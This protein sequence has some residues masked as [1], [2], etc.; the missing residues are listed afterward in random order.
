M[1]DG[2]DISLFKILFLLFIFVPLIEIYLLIE[3]GAHIGA[4]P[5]IALIIFTAVL[6]VFLLRLQGLMTLAKV[7]HSMD[8][9]E[10]P[11]A[12]LLEGL[13][14]LIAA[15][16]LLTP[17]FFTVLKDLAGTN[18]NYFTANRLFCGGVRDHDASSAGAFLLHALDDHAI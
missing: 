13:M 2:T 3:I 1:N 11:A 17:G 6:G 12:A 8:Q 9:G 7:R 16:L 14:L 18:G 4:M 15:A 5:T 10:L